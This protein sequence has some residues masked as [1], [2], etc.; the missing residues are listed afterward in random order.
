[1]S[2]EHVEPK[3]E[4][5]HHGVGH[6]DVKHSEVLANQAIMHDAYDGENYEHQM[7]VWAAFKSHPMACMWAFIMC[8][9]I[10]SFPRLSPSS[11]R[12]RNTSS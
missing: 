8:F 11:S 6:V 4:L 7:G 1:M 3:S 9:T 12:I 5:E 10:V 2:T